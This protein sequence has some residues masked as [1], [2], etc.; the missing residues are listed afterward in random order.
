MKGIRTFSSPES[1]FSSILQISPNRILL[2][3]LA[4]STWAYS[5]QSGFKDLE[6]GFWR[7]PSVFIS[8][9]YKRNIKEI[10]EIYFII[11]LY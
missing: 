3:L 9:R 8:R 10:I 7:H 2:H 11:Y 6:L 1:T 4:A 5:V